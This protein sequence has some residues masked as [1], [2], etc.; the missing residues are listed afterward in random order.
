MSHSAKQEYFKQ[1]YSRYR[2]ASRKEK[3]L[4]LNEFCTVCGYSRKY[5]ITK[6]N[7][8][9]P[10]LKRKKKKTGR[11]SI[12]NIPA[13]LEPL[14]IIW[15]YDNYPCSK[16]FKA[17][18][19][20]WLLFYEVE[21]EPL[22]P[23]IIFL[24]KRISPA[25]ID[26]LL[27]PMRNRINGK[28]IAT[29]KPGSILRSHIPYKTDQWQEHRPGFME[30]DTVAHCGTNA[31]GTFAFSL[32]MTCI[33]TTWTELRATFGKGEIGTWNQINDIEQS[34]PFPLMGFDSDGG[35]EFFNWHVYKKL[36]TRKEP[37]D[38]TTSRPYKKNDNAHVEQKNYTHVRQWI[39]YER[40]DYPE[41]VPLLNDLYKNALCP[42]LNCFT[43]SRKLVEKKRVASRTI[44]KHDLAKTPYQRVL[45]HPLVSEEAKTKL[46]KQCANLNPFALKR[47]ID[48]KSKHIFKKLS[49]LRLRDQQNKEAFCE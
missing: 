23:H 14:R 17:I 6:L 29:T 24:L 10:F 42:F 35:S 38:F 18:I 25:T 28:G 46:K 34:L 40:I 20:L 31:A 2:K 27:K 43:A 7:S 26:R 39:G 37:I 44:K 5:A 15:K 8:T 21:F 4:I 9:N 11:P 22:E 13:L 48:K 36:T 32:D 16:N 12:Y 3:T 33:A 47:S 41:I 49:A 1:I 19:P 30:V 45:A